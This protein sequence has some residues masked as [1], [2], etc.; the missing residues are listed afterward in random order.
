MKVGLKSKNTQYNYEVAIRRFFMWHVNK[1]IEDIDSNDLDILNEKMIRYQYHLL[2]DCDYSNN[3]VNALIAPITKLYE[4][5][6]RNRYNV[7]VDDVRVDKLPDDGERYGELT[8]SEAEMMAVLSAKQKKG[9][10]KSNLIRLAYTT[11]F[12]KASLLSI[13]WTDIIFD[14]KSQLYL[15]TAIG[16]RNKK[17]TRPIPIELYNELL[18]IKEQKYYA[19]YNDNKVFHLSDHTIQDMMDN[20]K[21]EM[22]IGEERNVVFHSLRN[23]AAGF[24]RFSGG[25]I[26]EIREQ[27]NQSG[28]GSLKHYMH[29]DK[30]YS[31]MAG[32]R[33]HETFEDNCL[34]QLN[35]E[36]LLRLIEQQ[37][38][39]VKTLLQ[40]EARKMVLHKK[41]S[42]E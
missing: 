13:E 27:L 2:D 15:V 42:G 21:K 22:G 3:T 12:R 40:R 37:S 18:K 23:V 10:E 35:R 8:H 32:M 34:E 41:E 9:I 28:Y 20:L 39:S 31:S 4:H 30:N 26:E 25:S 5:F 1:T 38:E 17:H 6:A 7:K 29:E 11:S 16:K 36:E 33:M 14:S 24:I 19:R